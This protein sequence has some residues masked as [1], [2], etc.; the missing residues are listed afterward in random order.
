MRIKFK[1]NTT[2]VLEPVL[3]ATVKKDRNFYYDMDVETR[4]YYIHITDLT[5]ASGE[6]VMLDKLMKDGY[7]DITE[8]KYTVVPK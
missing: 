2:F 5:T 7:L 1:D 6:P 4:G 8:N 3:T